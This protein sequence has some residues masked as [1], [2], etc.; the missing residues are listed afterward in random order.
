MELVTIIGL[1]KAAPDNV[2]VIVAII[3]IVTVLFIRMRDSDVASATSLGRM[4]SDNIK[5]LMEQNRDL[6][7]E[8][9]SLHKKLSETF[10]EMHK[11]RSQ[12]AELQRTLDFYKTK[13]DTCPGPGGK[14]VEIPDMF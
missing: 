3:A 2:L 4:Q 8:I 1:M 13:C 10:E 12:V 7:A 9:D 6:A 14:P 5:A 11:L